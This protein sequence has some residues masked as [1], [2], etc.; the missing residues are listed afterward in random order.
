MVGGGPAGA[1]AAIV[2]ARAGRS[3]RLI[4]KARFPRDKCCG[5]GLTTG[6]VRR[7]E[8]LGLDPRSVPSWK[9][10]DDVHVVSTRGH[11][12]TFP[13]PRN[14]GTFAA[15]ARRS[16]LDM[17]VLDLARQAGVVVIEGVG[18]I[19][20]AQ[21]LDGVTITA[22]DGRD[23]LG[24]IVVAADGMWSTVRKA[25][26][27]PHPPT[28]SA[29]YLG[30][31]HGYRQYFRD[32][33]ALAES[34]LWVW[35]EKD[36]DGGY[37]WSFPLAD[38]SANVGFGIE[39][40]PN[41]ATHVMKQLWPDLLARPHIRNVLGPDAVAE[42]AP[43]AW[44]IPADIRGAVLTSGRVLFV[45]DA[46]KACDMLTGEGI[47]QALQTGIYAGTAIATEF[48]LGGAAV[49]ERYQRDVRAELVPDH[50][51]AF[52]LQRMMRSS[53][54]CRGSLRV[55]GAT[56][57]TR[58]NFARWLFEDYARGIALTPRRWHRGA[59]SGAGAYV[60]D[61]VGPIPSTQNGN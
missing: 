50:R 52:A 54:I 45:G 23:Y 16:E 58:T 9:E 47:G 53:L 21:D 1:A 22:D 51:M 60:G 14:A 43:K 26:V 56:H 59:M 7:L 5:D 48:E 24:S 34:G 2:A 13:L 18:A 4:D 38:G 55:A 31:W 25:V 28:T 29:P 33:S 11:Q 49:A 8:A 19:G 15:I 37:V 39:R 40:R 30:E 12:V 20:V 42:G 35:F 32:V 27:G 57:W 6:A 3:V 41:R 44:P 36:L 61:V 17:S 10:L 46:A